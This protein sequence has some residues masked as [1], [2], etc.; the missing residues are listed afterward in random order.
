MILNTPHPIF[1]SLNQINNVVLYNLKCFSKYLYRNNYL[2]GLCALKMSNVL[3]HVFRH[4]ISNFLMPRKNNLLSFRSKLHIL[5]SLLM[6]VVISRLSQT[7]TITDEIK[8]I[9][10][11]TISLSIFQLS[12][13]FYFLGNDI[14]CSFDPNDNKII[15]WVPHG[16]EV[17]HWLCN[18]RLSGSILGAGNLEKL[19]IWM[20][21]HGVTQKQTVT[22]SQSLS[23]NSNDIPGAPPARRAHPS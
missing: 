5:S 15:Q 6:Y 1:T 23:A 17:E 2:R 8:I 10:K 7:K 12:N 13:N 21:F 11:F 9:L 16:V 19:F 3:R 18:P 22:E 14:S 20:I 4:F